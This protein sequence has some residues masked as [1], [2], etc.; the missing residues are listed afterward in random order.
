MWLRRENSCLKKPVVYAKP[1]FTYI[2]IK[3]DLF[4]KTN[5]SFVKNAAPIIP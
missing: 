4:L 5:I 2:I 3:K 1:P